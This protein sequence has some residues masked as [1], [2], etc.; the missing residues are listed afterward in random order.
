MILVP[1]PDAGPD[2]VVGNGSGAD[3]GYGDGGLQLLRNLGE[4]TFEV[5]PLASSSALFL[6]VGDFNGDCIPDVVASRW[7]QCGTGVV[8]NVSYGLRDG[9][10]GEP[11]ALSAPMGPAGVAVLGEVSHP[12]AI[13][14]ADYCGAGI[15]V[16]GDA[17][18]H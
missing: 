11:V 9:G 14:V 3:W 1:R 13:A 15:V 16:Y 10:F 6:A 12:S 4:G 17:S 8:L 7:E 5:E 18:R 2:L